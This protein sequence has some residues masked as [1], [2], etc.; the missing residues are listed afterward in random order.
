MPIFLRPSTRIHI[1]RCGKSNRNRSNPIP[2][3]SLAFLLAGS[4]LQG[5]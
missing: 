2:I 4:L 3:T 5:H 1:L